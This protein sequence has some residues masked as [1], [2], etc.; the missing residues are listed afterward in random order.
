VRTAFRGRGDGDYRSGGSR[1]ELIPDCG[2]RAG[3]EGQGRAGEAT[4]AGSLLDRYR[5]EIV[6]L[7]A[8]ARPRM[9]SL[10]HQTWETFSVNWQTDV[11]IAFRWLREA[12]LTPMR[13]G[14]SVVVLSSGAALNTNGSPLSGGYAGA[15]ATQHFITGYAQEEA[16][17]A[18]LGIT[19]T[20]VLPQFAPRQASAA[21]RFRPTQLAPACPWTISFTPRHSHCSPLRSLAPPSSTW[22]ERTPP[23]SHSP[24][25]STVPD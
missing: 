19:F 9:R 7:V 1:T 14:S 3:D 15:K 13:A 25:C 8:G 4:L 23:T 5:P 17:R 6:V 24:T 10:Q 22:Y 16:N 18:G 12:L 20:S 21:P 11:R 2:L